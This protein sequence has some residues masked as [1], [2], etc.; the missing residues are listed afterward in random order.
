MVA[1]VILVVVVIAAGVA[2]Y[3][4]FFVAPLDVLWA[5]LLNRFGLS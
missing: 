2:L 3:L 1:S 4:Q 5:A